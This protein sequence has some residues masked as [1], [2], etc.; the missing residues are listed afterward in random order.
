MTNK[1]PVA[2]ALVPP[3][4]IVATALVPPSS[5]LLPLTTPVPQPAGYTYTYAINTL[6]RKVSL[7]ASLLQKVVNN[8]VSEHKRLLEH[9]QEQTDYVHHDVQS[10]MCG[11]TI[12]FPELSK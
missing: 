3:S 6:E 8:K 2:T 7:L 10:L 11:F 5:I 4:S 12:E 9:V 1:T